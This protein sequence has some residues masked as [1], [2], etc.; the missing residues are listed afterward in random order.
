MGA[1]MA[2]D[3]AYEMNVPLAK[4]V[5]GRAALCAELER[6]KGLS[7]G[8]LPGSEVRRLASDG[9]AVFTERIDVSFDL[10]RQLGVDP[11]LFYD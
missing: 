9:N 7:T 3:I 11:A 5:H 4:P 2:D 6:Q 10:G 8:T 1:L